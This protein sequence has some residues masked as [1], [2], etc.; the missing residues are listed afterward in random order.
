MNPTYTDRQLFIMSELQK[1]YRF[2]EWNARL[3][4]EQDFQCVYC[5]KDFLESFDSYNS[6]QWDHIFP[7]SLGGD[8]TF[9]NIAVCCKTCNWLKGT[10]SPLGAT[11]EERIV[12]ARSYVQKQRLSYE[13]EVAQIR[14]LVRDKSDASA[15]EP[16]T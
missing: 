15:D 7:L 8:D 4:L 13:T 10:Y 11:R 5:A 9:E 12:D 1:H 2:G 3:G 6:W 14:R 16:S